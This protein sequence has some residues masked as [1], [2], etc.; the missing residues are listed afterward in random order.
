VKSTTAC[1]NAVFIT[2]P[3][4]RNFGESEGKIRRMNTA[5][6]HDGRVHIPTIDLSAFRDG[7][8]AERARVAADLD[9]AARTLGVVQVVGHDVPDEV[10]RGLTAAMDGF[11]NLPMWQKKALRPA[12]AEY[13]RGYTPPRSERLGLTLGVDSPADLFEMFNVGRSTADYPGLGLD[14]LQYAPNLWPLRPE[15]FEPGVKAWFR[16]ASRV[17]REV[18]SVMAVALGLDTD[19]FRGYQDHA[20]EV[21]RMHNYRPPAAAVEPQDGQV[22]ME[23]HTDHGIVTVRWSDPGV[24]SLQ[25]VDGQGVWRDVLPEPGA[26][27]VS[28]GDLLARWTN[29]R[30]I[31]PR[32]RLLPPTDETGVLVRRRSAALFHDG[33]ADALIS[34]LPGCADEEEPVRYESVT[35]AE[36]LAGKLNGS[37]GLIV[38]PSPGRDGGRLLGVHP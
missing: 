24:R 8:S 3:Y 14:E 17:A 30:W 27:L 15:H 18:T 31:S 4:R 36:H 32:H 9:T 20:L 6:T 23:P 38:K 5:R 37:L 2:G 26:L 7:S 33:N 12:S 34:V 22:A 16:Q 11:F 28:L 19:F 35:I 10:L 1:R 25:I 13:H 29:D 21:L